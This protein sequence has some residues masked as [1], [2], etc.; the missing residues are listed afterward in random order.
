MRIQ[1]TA[2]DRKALVKA[3]AEHLEQDAVY[4]GPPSFAYTIGGVTVD[5]EGVII[6]T[7][8]VDTTDIQGFLV[9]KGWLEPEPEPDRLTISVPVDGL[10]VQAMHNLILLLYSKQY[11]LGKA[12][13]EET[14]QID[15][16]V[17]E[18]LQQSAPE[19]PTDFRGLVD[20]F[21]AQ[22][23]IAGVGFTD[24]AVAISFP[25]SDRQ[26]VIHTYPLL[27]VNIIAAAKA[28]T[29]VLPDRQQPE[30]EKYYMRNWLVRLGFGG[31]ESKGMRTILLK[32]LKGHSAFRTDAEADKHR[33]KYAE[34]RRSHKES[35]VLEV[36]H[37]EG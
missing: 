1:S 28:A 30:N 4:C 15:D 27:T 34:I 3:L 13:R 18:R 26:D 31:K 37:E 20:E 14:I 23:Q 16:T 35:A 24:D 32:H 25:L 33:D 10:S 17:I 5:R 29:R 36:Q 19:T 7:E 21:K 22:R 12:L 8:D 2:P 6:L 11:L 9:S